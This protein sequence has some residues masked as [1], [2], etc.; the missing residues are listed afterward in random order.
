MY[1][2]GD[3]A[4]NPRISFEDITL[5][6]ITSNG[7]LFPAGVIRGNETNPLKNFIFEDVN[8]RSK[9]WDTLGVGFITEFTEGTSKNVFPDPGFKPDGYFAKNKIQTKIE[10]ALPS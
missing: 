2:L 9:V 7:A 1:P 5:R 8:L 4:T 6:N 3:C 10:S